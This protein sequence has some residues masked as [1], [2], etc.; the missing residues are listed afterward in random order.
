MQGGAS[1]HERSSKRSLEDGE[2]KASAKVKV[3]F[4]MKKPHPHDVLCGR[5]GGTNNHPG[6]EHFRDL[7]NARKVAYLHSSKRKKPLVSRGIVE[8][9][10]SMD[11]PGRFLLKDESTGTWRD[12]GDQKA[13]EKTSQ[14]LREGA[15]VIRRG[16]SVGPIPPEDASI[17]GMT[18]SDP[19][20]AA[21]LTLTTSGA[22]GGEPSRLPPG[23]S[24]SSDSRYLMQMQQDRAAQMIR[25]QQVRQSS[26]PPQTQQGHQQIMGAR[27]QPFPH[28]PMDLHQRAVSV[29]MS[30][31]LSSGSPNQ[32]A[33]LSGF[34]GGSGMSGPTNPAVAQWLAQGV[35]RNQQHHES[36]RNRSSNRFEVNSNSALGQSNLR[37][38]EQQQQS[39]RS[40]LPNITGP[41][42]MGQQNRYH[43]TNTPH[44]GI[45]LLAR[46]MISGNLVSGGRLQPLAPEIKQRLLLAE[47]SSQNASEQASME[48]VKKSDKAAALYCEAGILG[49]DPD[50]ISQQLAN[51]HDLSSIVLSYYRQT[52]GLKNNNTSMDENALI[53]PR[54]IPNSD[55]TSGVKSERIEEHET[56]NNLEETDKIDSE[57]VNETT[58]A[59]LN[60]K[61]D[62]GKF[63]DVEESSYSESG[64]GKKRKLPCSDDVGAFDPENSTSALGKRIRAALQAIDAL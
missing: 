21:G 62:D 52:T 14:A 53:L 24:Q 22:S 26:A 29:A 43:S 34:R 12:I 63:D 23:R 56:S 35:A 51:G 47:W 5:G 54:K 13:R 57:E 6:N 41:P 64:G 27:Q 3:N 18:S 44:S 37:Q 32:Q 40:Y 39:S 9:I 8:T 15:P 16:I 58:K 2:G 25:Q 49:I 61:N 50:H 46:A 10:R 20:L 17:S 7:V 11:P 31:L 33:R 30:G 60:E 42:G 36:I 45:S 19:A 59:A 28:A 1:N 55:D 38:Q 48:E 4:N